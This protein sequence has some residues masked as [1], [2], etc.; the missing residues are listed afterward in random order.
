VLGFCNVKLRH[1]YVDL[2]RKKVKKHTK[3]LNLF[4][5]FSFILPL[6]TVLDMSKIRNNIGFDALLVF[7]HEHNE[8]VVNLPIVYC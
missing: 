6:I 2:N 1:N 8:R 5:F 4:I 3:L 7:S